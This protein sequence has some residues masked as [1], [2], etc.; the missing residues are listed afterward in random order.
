[1]KEEVEEEPFTDPPFFEKAMYDV[2]LSD[3]YATHAKNKAK[4]SNIPD[5]EIK[6]YDLPDIVSNDFN[7][8]FKEPFV[9]GID[10]YEYIEFRQNPSNQSYLLFDK[11]LIT[12]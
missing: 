9:Y 12:K 11:N 10:E 7:M 8:K 4:N 5:L 2:V 1:V 3:D 6:R